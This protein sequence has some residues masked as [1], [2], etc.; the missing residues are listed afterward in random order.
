MICVRCYV[1]Q[2]LRTLFFKQKAVH[3]ELTSTRTLTCVE[4]ANKPQVQIVEKPPGLKV[5]TLKGSLCLCTKK[6]CLS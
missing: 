3:N 5:M 2:K 4:E 6:N 1:H